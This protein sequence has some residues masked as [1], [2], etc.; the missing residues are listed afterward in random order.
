MLSP[1]EFIGFRLHSGD[2]L[3]T[4]KPHVY[5]RCFPPNAVCALEALQTCCA[6]FFSL[7]IFLNL[8]VLH[9]HLQCVIL[10]SVPFVAKYLYTLL[11]DS[12]YLKKKDRNLCIII[13]RYNVKQFLFLAP[14]W[15]S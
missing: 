15:R 12:F 2:I 7:I 11:T 9:P 1:S 10:S 8:V 14:L 6:F 5:I 3:Q 4:N 13:D